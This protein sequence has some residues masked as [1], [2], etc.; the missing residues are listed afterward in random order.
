MDP[1]W[2][3]Y[4]SVEVLEDRMAELAGMSAEG[5]LSTPTAGSTSGGRSTTPERGA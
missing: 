5:T 2:D 4:G 3:Y 1:D